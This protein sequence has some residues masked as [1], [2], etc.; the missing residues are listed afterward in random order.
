MTA[1]QRYRWGRRNLTAAQWAR[2]P[3]ARALGLPRRTVSYRLA[4]GWGAERAVTT[5]SGATYEAA[6]ERAGAIVDGTTRY[7]DDIAAQLCVAAFP[8]GMELEE[9]GE[10]MGMSRQRVQQIEAQALESLRRRL[11]LAGVRAEDLGEAIALRARR[12]AV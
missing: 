6:R 10:A 7:A 2:E 8:G 3:E 9:I 5:P 11:R 4:Q 12:E 1:P